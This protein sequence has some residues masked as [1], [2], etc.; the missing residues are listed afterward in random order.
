M[1]KSIFKP[2]VVN[3]KVAKRAIEYANSK[4]YKEKRTNQENEWGKMP[5]AKKPDED[6]WKRFDKNI[7]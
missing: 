7:M 2:I 4:K 1:T 6:F 3:P 5:L